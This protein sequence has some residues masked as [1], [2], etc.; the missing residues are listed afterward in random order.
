MT[1]TVGG[2]I[3]EVAKKTKTESAGKARAETIGGVLF[4]KS[5][6]EMTSSTKTTRITT[7]G[8]ALTVSAT[9][10]LTLTGTLK[11]AAK[12]LLGEIAGSKSV[13][14]K[15]GDSTVVLEDGLVHIV[16]KD[17]IRLKVTGDNALAAGEAKQN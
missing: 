2:A 9:K 6:A 10:A 15:V 5:G 4:S 16:A 17:E 8:G 7:V 14:L 13:T 11:V 12:S 1:L 3:I